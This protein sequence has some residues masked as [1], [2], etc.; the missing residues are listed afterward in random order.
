M[1]RSFKF[2]T[3]I[4]LPKVLFIFRTLKLRKEI[5]VVVSWSYLPTPPLAQDMTQ[6][7]FLSG[8]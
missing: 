8:V 5:F 2:P 1:W 7:Q 4:I 6:V 3:Y